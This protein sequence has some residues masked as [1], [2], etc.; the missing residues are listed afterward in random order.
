[1]ITD[2]LKNDV[3]FV[4]VDGAADGFSEERAGITDKV[5][6]RYKELG[7]RVIRFSANE[8]HADILIPQFDEHPYKGRL[9]MDTMYSY[10]YFVMRDMQLHLTDYTHTIRFE[11]DG[12]PI[13][14]TKW[15]D[16]FLNYDLLAEPASHYRYDGNRYGLFGGMSLKSKKADKILREKV[17][18]EYWKSRIDR[19]KD[20]NE[21][22]ITNDML[23]YYKG[24]EW[25][26]IFSK[27][28][29]RKPDYSAFGF[30]ESVSNKNYDD[31]VGV[32]PYEIR[33]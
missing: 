17:T 29:S 32:E 26:D 28:H 18:T 21:D 14:F 11:W 2:R 6:D 20:Y 12:Y 33:V 15:T 16:D 27:W 9:V 23:T 3:I 30:H 25:D 5:V 7:L 22:V 31:L 24:W 13:D 1:M 19:G 8:N 10:P 4:T